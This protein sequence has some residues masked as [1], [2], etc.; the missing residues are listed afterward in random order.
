MTLV[1]DREGAALINKK[2]N[3]QIRVIQSINMA[4]FSQISRQTSGQ[5]LFDS[6][7]GVAELFV[8]EIWVQILA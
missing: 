2:F 1:V 5:K 7:S 4:S 3:I 8:L 6:E